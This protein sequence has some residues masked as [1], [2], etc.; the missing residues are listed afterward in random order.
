[1]SNITVEPVRTSKDLMAFIKLQWKIYKGD[2]YWV[3]PLIMDRKK[4]VDTKK[5]PF[6]KHSDM[7]MFLARKDGEVVGRIAGIINYNHNKFQEEEIGFFGFFESINDQQ[8]ANSLLDTAK[9]WIAKRDSG[10][11]A[12]R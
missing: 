5:N 1:M 9:D 4:L 6:Y 3:P 7:E 8:V 11:C 10:Q 2:P 12:G